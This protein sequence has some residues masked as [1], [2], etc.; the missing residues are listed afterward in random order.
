MKIIQSE[1][2][3]VADYF[4][5]RQTLSQRVENNGDGWE[6]TTLLMI[7]LDAHVTRIHATK[8]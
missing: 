3:V 2:R 4:R 5:G 8:C 1:L 7:R 6:N